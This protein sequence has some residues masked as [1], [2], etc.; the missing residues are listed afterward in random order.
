MNVLVIDDHAIF[1]GGVVS[2]LERADPSILVVECGSVS[3]GLARIDSGLAVELMLLD[4][5]MP[6]Y[7]GTQALEEVRE[8]R[9]EIP[10]LVLSGQEDAKLVRKCVDLGAFGFLP[11]SAPA[12]TLHPALKLVLAGGVFLPGSSLSV[13]QDDTL[14]GERSATPWA[15]LGARLTDRQRDVLLRIAQ[16]KPNKV[17]ANELGLSDYTVKTHVTNIFNALGLSNRTQAVYALARAGISIHEL[18]TAP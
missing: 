8:K 14:G 16:G 9:P 11:K 17:I 4:L 15:R 7:E 10:V 3:A 6:G 2:Q 1:R 12:G 13:A 18:G 5:H